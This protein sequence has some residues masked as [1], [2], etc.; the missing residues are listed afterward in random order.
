[1]T[2]SKVKGSALLFFLLFLLALAAAGGIFYLFQQ[3]RAK[4]ASLQLELEDVRAKQKVT[5]KE[6]S[7]SRNKISVLEESL[8]S[9]DSKVQELNALV[10]QERSAKSQALSEIAKLNEEIAQHK[11]LSSD[12]ESKL[13]QAQKDVDK[14]KKQLKELDA[15][16]MAL[17]SRM[18]E[19]EAGSADVELGKIVV[20]QSNDVVA[21]TPQSYPTQ[22]KQIEQ[23][24]NINAEGKVLVV[25]KEY[26]FAVINLGSKD[27]VG[28]GNIFTVYHD[29]KNIG[30]LKVEKIHDSMSAAGFVSADMKNKVFEGDKVILKSR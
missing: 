16:R 5:E 17:E 13:A 8:R 20:N 12:L 27:G 10:E 26:N 2:K 1:M 19:M 28:I 22:K 30:D 9:A 3:E 15:K 29:N 14:M 6:L 7:E 23:V 11:S 21:Q 25:N 24:Q 18:Q 4:T